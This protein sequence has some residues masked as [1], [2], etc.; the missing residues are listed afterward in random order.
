MSIK[1]P[2]I[3]EV[4]VLLKRYMKKQDTFALTF[5]LYFEVHFSEP[6][7]LIWVDTSPAFCAKWILVSRIQ[8]PDPESYLLTGIIINR[9]EIVES[10]WD[11]RCRLLSEAVLK[12]PVQFW[13]LFSIQI[14][15]TI[16]IPSSESPILLL[17][18]HHI[19]HF[20]VLALSPAFGLFVPLVPR[21][22]ITGDHSK[23]RSFP[24][25]YFPDNLL[26]FYIFLFSAMSE[27]Y[28]RKLHYFKLSIFIE[29]QLMLFFFC[30][31]WRVTQGLSCGSHP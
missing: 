21:Y 26:A 25:N 9:K 3:V 1:F 17:S 15:L 19:S 6:L 14:R 30:T 7:N 5:I 16:M 29:S 10:I 2:Y 4:H 31:C 12:T 11:T 20:P 28:V 23:V 18:S 13:K 24:L 22:H 8:E 27:M